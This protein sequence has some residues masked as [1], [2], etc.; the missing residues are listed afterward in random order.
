MSHSRYAFAFAA[1]SAFVAA[2]ARGQELLVSGY[3]SDEVHRFDYANG[4]YLGAL[5]AANG[6]HA[7]VTGADGLLYIA[8]EEDDKV[9]R[10]DPATLLFKDEFVFEARGSIEV[11]GKGS[12]EAWLLK[13]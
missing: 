4:N 13:L 1:F 11:K 9:V 10:Y 3:T 5:A 2:P 8:V 6:A 12:V 7:V